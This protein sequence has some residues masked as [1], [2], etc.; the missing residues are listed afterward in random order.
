MRAEGSKGT[1]LA[2]VRV[3]DR[4]LRRPGHARLQISRGGEGR[5]ARMRGLVGRP[6]GMGTTTS[7]AADGSSSDRGV[8]TETEP[9]RGGETSTAAEG[10]AKWRSRKPGQ[11]EVL[12]AAATTLLLR[13]GQCTASQLQVCPAFHTFEGA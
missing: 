4:R 5:G 2:A 8:A 9:E 3:P 11:R 10:R 12:N 13:G 1:L 6:R 7:S